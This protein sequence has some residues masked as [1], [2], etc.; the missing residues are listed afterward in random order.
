MNHFA[1]KDMK[2]AMQSITSIIERGAK[3]QRNFAQGTAQY[4]LQANRI[5]A[6]RIALSLIKNELLENGLKHEFLKEDL[7]KAVAPMASLISKSEKAQKKLTP[8][9]WQHTMLKNNLEALSIASQL[10]TKA[11]GEQ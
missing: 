10:L 5:G 6:L 9:T 8:G 1:D 7:E 11:L 3:A 4:T 2:D